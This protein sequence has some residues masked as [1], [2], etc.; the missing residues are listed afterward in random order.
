MRQYLHL[1]WI[2][3]SVVACSGNTAQDGDSRDM[4][5]TPIAGSDSQGPTAGGATQ[6]S[7]GAASAGTSSGGAS[8]AGSGATTGGTKNTAGAS[9]GGAAG[10][11]TAGTSSAGTTG[12]AGAPG[13]GKQPPDFKFPTSVGADQKL[14]KT[15]TVTDFDGKLARY[16]GTGDLGGTGQGEGQDPLFLVKAG[17]SL[18][19]VILGTPAADGVHCVVGRRGR[20]RHYVRGQG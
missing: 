19:N 10:A 17:G 1:V 8:S 13:N 18:K 11:G 6:P 16:V 4:T 20:R 2:L 5:S 14:S 9:S 3:G 15:M 7:G 12:T